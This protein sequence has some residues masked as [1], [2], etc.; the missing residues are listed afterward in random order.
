MSD[1]QETVTEHDVTAGY[2]RTLEQNNAH[3]Q[4]LVSYW[5]QMYDTEQQRGDT[6]AQEVT[7]LTEA[8]QGLTAER[9]RLTQVFLIARD[10]NERL[11]GMP[12]KVAELEAELSQ[13]E[14]RLEMAHRIMTHI[15]L[16]NYDEMPAPDENDGWAL[17]EVNW[18]DAWLRGGDNTTPIAGAHRASVDRLRRLEAQVDSWKGT[19]AQ[20]QR[21]S[22]FY[23]GLVVKIGEMFGDAA[24][25]SNDSNVQEDVLALKVPELVQALHNDLLVTQEALIAAQERIHDQEA[26]VDR[27]KSLNHE[28]NLVWNKAEDDANKLRTPCR[29]E[30][31]GSGEHCNGVCR[32]RES[33]VRRRVALGPLWSSRMVNRTALIDLFDSVVEEVRHGSQ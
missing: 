4:E 5:R 25:T 29:C 16:W 26:H 6:L 28:Y 15:R 2:I 10:E 8:V 31:P 12:A 24:K 18:L 19:A 1:D 27:L 11:A 20:C 3:L 7:T 14:S 32:V 30:P 33:L 9:D 17:V 22:D 13:Q 23:R 21:N